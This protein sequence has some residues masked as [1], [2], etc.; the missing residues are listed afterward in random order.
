MKRKQ[1]MAITV[2]Q[3]KDNVHQDQVDTN[4]DG[5]KWSAARCILKVEAMGFPHRMD[6]GYEI[7]TGISDVSNVFC[8][9][10]WRD[11]VAINCDGES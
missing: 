7:K 3:A 9:T 5:K 2:I 11:G 8:L 1:L 4:T 6:I 10:K